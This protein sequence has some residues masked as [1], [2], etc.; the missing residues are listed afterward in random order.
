MSTEPALTET[1]PKS[2][3]LDAAESLFIE[4]GVAGTS[5]R[6][7]NTAAGMNPAAVHYH[8]GSKETL[9]LEVMRRRVDPANRQRLELLD[10]LERDAAGEPVELE[11]LIASFLGPALAGDH[12]QLVAILHHESKE[13]AGRI[14]P[15]LFGGVAQRFVTAI[16]RGLPHL[17][18]DEVTL[19]F[20]FTVGVML[21][22]MRGFC[23]FSLDPANPSQV[24]PDPA[25]RLRQLVAF[26][27]AGFRAPPS[28][29]TPEEVPHET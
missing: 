13:L 1:D 23:D 17:T 21:H 26:T 7:I 14:T 29:E 10:A 3:I 25:T 15:L 18:T 20:K 22:V 4:Q 27:A 24:V 12:S 8:F 5:L 11:E 6:S 28:T 16:A 2:R 19:R 9:L